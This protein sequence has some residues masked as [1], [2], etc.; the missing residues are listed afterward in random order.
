MDGAPK[1]ACGSCLIAVDA[2]FFN[3]HR[4]VQQH[5]PHAYALGEDA[6]EVGAKK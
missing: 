5:L 6:S 1:T 3:A 4:M 2:S